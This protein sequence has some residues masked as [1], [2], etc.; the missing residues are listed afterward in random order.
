MSI[1]TN[2]PNAKAIQTPKPAAPKAAELK[3]KAPKPAATKVTEPKAK[4]PKAKVETTGNPYLDKFIRGLAAWKS[5]TLKKIETATDA[6]EKQRLQNLVTDYDNRIRDIRNR[7]D[8]PY[9]QK[10]CKQYPALA[11]ALGREVPRKDKAP[12]K[13]A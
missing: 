5:R 13:A 3:A 8:S 11:R 7:A 12:A 1:N 9:V 6:A 10:A 2:T 4:A